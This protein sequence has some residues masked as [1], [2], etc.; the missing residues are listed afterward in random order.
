MFRKTFSFMERTN[1]VASFQNFV[2]KWHFDLEIGG[3]AD[4]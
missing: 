2:T 4:T 3:Q 1:Y